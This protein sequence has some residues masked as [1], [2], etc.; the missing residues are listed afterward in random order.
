[1]LGW[2]SSPANNQ[3]CC[4][5]EHNSPASSK[6]RGFNHYLVLIIVI[7]ICAFYWIRQHDNRWQKVSRLLPDGTLVVVENVTFGTNHQLATW[8]SW[9]AR[10]FDL[11]PDRLEAALN[12]QNTRGCSVSGDENIAVIW[13]TKR[14]STGKYSSLDMDHAEIVD[15][16][17]CHYECEGW[18]VCGNSALM[19]TALHFRAAP[20]RT[21]RYTL[22]VFGSNNK[23][24]TE[25]VL[26]NPN[27]VSFP[28]WKPT[29]LPA[30]YRTNGFTITLKSLDA[31]GTIDGSFSSAPSWE[32]LSNGIP[33]PQWIHPSVEYEDATGNRSYS[34]C[35]YESAWKLHARFYR[36]EESSYS[37]EEIWSVHKLEMPVPGQYIPVNRRGT[38]PN[39]SL[40]IVGIVGPGSY[41]FSNGV[42]VARSIIKPP[43]QNVSCTTQTINGIPVETLTLI[44]GQTSLLMHF[45]LARSS[46]LIVR[47]SNFP[48][49]T[50]VTRQSGCNQWRILSL[51]HPLVSTNV[52]L[53][54]MIERPVEAEFMVEPPKIAK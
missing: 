15:Q 20:R 26:A 46:K 2:I 48:G 52:D 3:L 49:Q 17:G 19:Y 53:E 54:L 35:R 10:L 5:Q 13:L 51:D 1:M 30:S 6:V 16:H 33:A 22:K 11:L 21:G 45:E 47:S 34:L 28:E 12:L 24:A 32:V 31:F 29:P 41:T 18:S 14:D 37:A 23:L 25:F 8:P 27:S 39:G 50:P 44:A 42:C 7:V 43:A 4:S 40:E 36:N 9:E 38:L